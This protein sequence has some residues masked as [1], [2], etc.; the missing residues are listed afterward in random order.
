VFRPGGKARRLDDSVYAD[1]ERTRPRQILL[2]NL[3]SLSWSCIDAASQRRSLLFTHP[4][5]Q[6]LALH[7]HRNHDLAYAAEI[8]ELV[9]GLKTLEVRSHAPARDVEA[10]VIEL[11]HRLRE[12]R[13]VVVPMYFLTSAV[14][15][16]LATLAHLEA[17]DL[18]PPVERG[19]GDRA[20]VATFA[21]ALPSGAFAALQR[22]ALTAH[23]Q[24]ALAF[25]AQPA[26]PR[27]LV[28]LHL[29]VLAIDNP[30]VL[31]ALL[32]AL[33]AHYPRLAV[34]HVDFVLGPHTPLLTPAPPPA[35]RPALDTLRPLAAMRLTALD[36][37]WDY[38]LP[39]TDAELATLA[40]SWPALVRL[41]LHAEPVP[42]DV[43]PRLTL[44]ALLPLATHCPRLHTLALYLDGDAA[45][46]ARPHATTTTTTAAAPYPPRFRALA[47]LAL[48][49]S[50]LSAAGLAPAVLFLSLVLPA[51][52]CAVGAGVRW[53]DAAG[54]VFDAAG[55]AGAGSAR[56]AEWWARW[57][58]VA[59]VL[60]LVV[61]A[62]EDERARAL[63]LY[64]QGL[65]S[66]V[67]MEE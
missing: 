31:H 24:H 63:A 5:M 17:V 59:R 62:R 53:P 60:P 32:A 35:A 9:P 45:P 7:I 8:A 4:G 14:A 39:L 54:L 23:L 43:P 6:H 48:G 18:A 33:A 47:R 27:H 15:A 16:E 11:I 28:A 44:G 51:R 64:R 36:L 26:A 29:Y 46:P 40:R 19:T 21:P 52:G 20:D 41:H 38:P 49:A 30:P 66:E 57:G 56:M 55:V 10:E 65:D 37:R 42:E 3:Q 2:P 67:P 50:P 58:E 1:I 25:L 22:L 34:L 13:R 12:L 61:R